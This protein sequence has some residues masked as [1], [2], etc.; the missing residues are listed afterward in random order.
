MRRKKVENGALWLLLLWAAIGYVL[1]HDLFGGTLLAHSDWDSYSLQA[2][3]WLRGQTALDQNYPWLEL[4]VYN[5]H[6]YVS[7][8]PVPS[9]VLLPFVALFGVRTPNNLIIAAITMASAAMAYFF[10]RR[11]GSQP[12]KAAFWAGF[13]V[14]GS[15]LLWMSTNGGV[16]FMAQ[17]LN[18]AFCY[19][20]LLA[21]AYGRRVAAYALLALA[22]GSRPFSACYFPVLMAWF[23]A[24]DLQKT[25]AKG[26][27]AW[28]RAIVRQAPAWVLPALIAGAMM[29]YNAVRF[30]NPLEFGHNYLPEFT[31]SEH[32]QF[33]LTYLLSNLLRLLRPVVPTASGGLSYPVFDGFAFFIANPLFSVLGIRLLQ[34]LRHRRAP[35]HT[36]LLLACMAANLLLLC[37][38]KTLGGWQFGARYTVDLL[39]FALLY[40]ARSGADRPIR[41]WETGLCGF[42]VLFNAYGALA[43]TFLYA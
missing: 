12:R 30:G 5:G 11:M 32:G 4:A 2:A 9:V 20:T 42:A 15:N 31:Q 21:A 22:V 38:H 19:G 26:P 34:D 7:F 13:A 17:A 16:W 1:L 8:P 14:F 23:A 10:M 25:D 43:M 33:S 6:Y 37:L 27:G 3:A 39:P 35:R 18:A 28:A 40:L 29:A 41:A 36:G 24:K